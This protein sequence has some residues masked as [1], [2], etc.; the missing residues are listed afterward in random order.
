MLV[1]HLLQYETA[2][3][4]EIVESD[5]PGLAGRE[6]PRLYPVELAVLHQDIVNVGVFVETNDLNTILRLLAGD[7]LHIDV[8][9]NGIVASAADL[10]MLVI[11]VDLQYA[12]FA[13]THLDVLH[14]DV[15]DDTASTGIRLDAQHTLQ[16]RR[17]HHTVVGKDILAT[18]GYLRSDNHTAVTVLHLAVADDDVL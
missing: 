14:I 8:A 9:D 2:V 18:S 5:I 1:G 12:L 10:I 15:L 7:V 11:E 16:L 3:Q 13:D 17:V 4:E 6:I